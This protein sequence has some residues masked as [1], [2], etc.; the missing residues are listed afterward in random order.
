MMQTNINK[1]FPMMKK[2]RFEF[3]LAAILIAGLA[4]RLYGINW[5]QGFSY[6]PHPDERAILMKV[7]EIHFPELSNLSTLLDKDESPWNP[8]WFPYGSF[9]LY[10]LEISENILERMTGTVV[11]DLRT[12]ARSISV[13]ADLGT[14]IGIAM[15]GKSAFSRR[16]GLLAALLISFSVIHIQLAHFF[17]FD[18]LTVFFTTW[19]LLVLY[20]LTFSGKRNHS[21]LAGALIGLGLATKVS[22]LPI[23]GAFVMAHLIYAA[24]DQTLEDIQYWKVKKA[25]ISGAWGIVAGSLIFVLAQP[26]A[27]LDWNRFIGDVTEQSEMVR[28]IRDYPYTRQYIG[29]TPYVYQFIQMGK[30]GLGWPLTIVSVVG[31][32][33]ATSK[34]LKLVHAILSIL[35]CAIIP[36]TV[37]L[38]NNSA[39]AIVVS[40]LICFF[41]LIIF[42]PFQGKGTSIFILLLSWVLPYLL[43]TG[44]SLIHI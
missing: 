21:L 41:S 26:Y 44:L 36:A 17:A 2:N 1:L 37:L 7:E 42:S 20:R 4:I 18:T 16:V 23:A 35:Y 9:P 14:I 11:T 6:S 30:W 15:L 8:R 34:G 40:S 22:L 27:L 28:R 43:V 19:S 32:F 3:L 13:L 29:T 10:V 5:D 12:L 25:L 33:W 39:P 24:R 31:L 38:W